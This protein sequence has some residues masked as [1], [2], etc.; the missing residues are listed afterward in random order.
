MRVKD[1]SISMMLAM[2]ILVL[3]AATTTVYAQ[4]R[5]GGNGGGRPA[6][7]GPP[8]GS[9]GVDRG[10]GNASSRLA[11]APT[12]GLAMHRAGQTGAPTPVTT[13]RGWPG[14]TLTG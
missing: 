3:S 10:L 5:G 7:A 12:P 2:A 6:T 1:L 4:G 11:G 13:V 9:P 8:M 14:I